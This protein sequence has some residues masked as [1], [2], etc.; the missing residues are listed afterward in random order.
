MLV[1]R[2]SALASRRSEAF[3][4]LALRMLGIRQRLE[5]DPGF[6][7]ELA[8]ALARARSPKLLVRCLG[9]TA[10]PSLCEVSNSWGKIHRRVVYRADATTVHA[11]PCRDLLVAHRLNLQ[12]SQL[13][14][15]G[16]IGL[17]KEA[18]VM[19]HSFMLA[20]L[21]TY[22][23]ALML[24]V[25]K[26]CSK[27]FWRM[28]NRMAQWST[29]QQPRSQSARTQSCSRMRPWTSSASAWLRRP[30][31]IATLC[32]PSTRRPTACRCWRARSTPHPTSPLAAPSR[33]P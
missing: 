32:M 30:T 29:P 13:W 14:Q 19:L 25:T 7:K 1:N 26:S 33:T 17:A 9:M 5:A 10:H 11:A 27:W 28:F 15:L 3:G 18:T 16:Y 20:A 24:E 8:M 6:I 31:P 21:L 2:R 12:E 23:L 22:G 4:S